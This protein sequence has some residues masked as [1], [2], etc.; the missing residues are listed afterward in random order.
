[1][2]TYVLDPNSKTPLYEQLYRALKEDMLCKWERIKEPSQIIRVVFSHPYKA[3]R[4]EPYSTRWRVNA[5]S[6]RSGQFVH[7]HIRK[8]VFLRPVSERIRQPLIDIIVLF[9]LHHHQPPIHTIGFLHSEK[10]VFY[11]GGD[12]LRSYDIAEFKQFLFWIRD[13]E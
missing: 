9:V 4:V 3:V 1:M 7:S 5:I 2:R 12:F 13:T 8:H 10:A 6:Y 11:A